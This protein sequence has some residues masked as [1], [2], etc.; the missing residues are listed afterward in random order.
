MRIVL[1]SIYLI[2]FTNTMLNFNEFKEQIQIVKLIII[3]II[4]KTN[5]KVLNLK[6]FIDTH[7]L[8]EVY[9]KNFN[10]NKKKLRRSQDLR[11]IKLW[12]DY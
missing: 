4:L 1:S 3:Y 7:T 2:K 6:E 9:L 5:Y 12:L 11:L 8:Y 10:I